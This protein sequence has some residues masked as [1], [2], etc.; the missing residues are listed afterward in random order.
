MREE[1][2][3]ELLTEAGK[4]TV[5][6]DREYADS[7]LQ[8]AMVKNREVFKNGKERDDM[9]QAFWELFEP[10]IEEQVMNG[11][12]RGENRKLISL[13]IKKIQRGKNILSISDALEEPVDVIRPIYEAVLAS[14]GADVGQIYEMAYLRNNM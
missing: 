2:A 5:K 8:I 9:C 12:K 10:E 3:R 11:E 7:V 6:N 14:A 4:L 1:D 13:I